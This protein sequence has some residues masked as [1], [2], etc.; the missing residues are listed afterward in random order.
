[1]FKNLL[2]EIVNSLKHKNEPSF[3][4]SIMEPF[5]KLEKDGEFWNNTFD[6][7]AV[8]ANQNK[9]IPNGDRHQNGSSAFG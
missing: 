8:L 5:Y 3:I 6:G 7:I 2:R 1:M 4:D 9:W